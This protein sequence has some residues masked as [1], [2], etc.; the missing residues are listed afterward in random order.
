MT[1]SRVDRVLIPLLKRM[2]DGDSIN[3]VS[4]TNWFY[5]VIQYVSML[6]LLLKK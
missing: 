4:G 1:K 3:L 6:I 2:V 5:D